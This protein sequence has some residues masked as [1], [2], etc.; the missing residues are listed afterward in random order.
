[1]LQLQTTSQ[2]VVE[3]KKNTEITTPPPTLHIQLQMKWR[4]LE[5]LFACWTLEL[6]SWLEFLRLVEIICE[7][8]SYLYETNGRQSRSGSRRRDSKQGLLDW[9]GQDEKA[10]RKIRCLN[11]R[12]VVLRWQLRPCVRVH[13]VSILVSVYLKRPVWRALVTEAS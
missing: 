13:S 5:L 10:N 7:S 3:N 2:E 9:H 8:S 6:R 1:M 12:T 11:S 4:E